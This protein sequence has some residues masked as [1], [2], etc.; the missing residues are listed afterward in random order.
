MDRFGGMLNAF[1]DKEME[2]CY[3][4]TRV[5]DEHFPKAFDVL[6]DIVLEPKF[7]DEDIVREKIRR[8]RRNRHQPRITLRI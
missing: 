2:K 3:F 8:A 4:H 5:L 6:A 7:A 1:T